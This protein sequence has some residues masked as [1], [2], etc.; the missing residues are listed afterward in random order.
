MSMGFTRGKL[1]S[2]AS[3]FRMASSLA[4]PRATNSSTMDF[5]LSISSRK[6]RNTP[7]SI[8]PSSSNN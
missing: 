8:T 4:N 6:A 3:R 7:G 2:S 1:N 5:E